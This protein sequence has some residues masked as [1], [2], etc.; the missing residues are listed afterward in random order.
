MSRPARTSLFCDAE[1]RL[2]AMVFVTEH[3]RN[4]TMH[5]EH[6]DTTW[7]KV[8]TGLAVLGIITFL[9]LL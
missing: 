8:V 7:S 5:H 2:R 3:R 6:V 9:F 4:H 1:E